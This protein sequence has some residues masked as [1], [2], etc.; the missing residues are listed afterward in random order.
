[1][2]TKIAEIPLPPEISPAHVLLAQLESCEQTIEKGFKGV[3]D[4]GRALRAVRD[5]RL[6]LARG[7]NTFEEY[8]LDWWGFSRARARQL[9]LAAE[10]A[11]NVVKYLEASVTAGNAPLPS[12][13]RQLRPLMALPPAEQ[14]EVWLDA[15]KLAGSARLTA[16]HVERAADA[17]RALLMPAG[18]LAA[19]ITV[20]STVSRV[21]E[22]PRPPQPSKDERRR[23][24]AEQAVAA[25]RDLLQEL[26]TADSAAVGGV[27]EALEN[28][29]D[30]QQH[31][32]QINRFHQAR[33]A[34]R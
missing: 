27:Q 23:A 29:E 2:T 15:I 10:T 26:G 12:N 7:F 17:R 6:F 34:V 20:E 18:T 22:I 16:A 28:L 30:L 13:E 1:M 25:V 19:A 5:D 3:V 9:C 31:L 4:A 32:T 33:E 14:G 11:G 21:A 8:C 24:K